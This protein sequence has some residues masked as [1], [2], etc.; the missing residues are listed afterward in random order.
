LDL[1][2]LDL[3][4]IPEMPKECLGEEDDE[5]K[6]DDDEE[7]DS[8]DDEEEEEEEDDGEDEELAIAGESTEAV[9][10][11]AV[12]VIDKDRLQAWSDELQKLIDNSTD[13]ILKDDEIADEIRRWIRSEIKDGLEWDK[14]LSDFTIEKLASQIVKKDK[15]E[16][17]KGK[18][19]GGSSLQSDAIL[20]Q[21]AERIELEIA[22]QT[23]RFD[24]ASI[25]NG[26][27]VVREGPRATSR[28]LVQSLPY[29]NRIMAHVGLRFYGYG[30]DAA[31]TPTDPPGA[32]GQCW[33]FMSEE[34]S[35]KRQK[36]KVAQDFSRGSVA[37]LTVRLARPTFV[38]SIV[39]EHPPKEITDRM[40][41]AIRAFRVVG[42]EDKI[43]SKGSY[44]LGRFAYKPDDGPRAEFDVA[45]KLSR[46]DVPKLR[47]IV[48]AIESTWGKSDDYGCLYRFRVHGDDNE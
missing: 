9:V 32:L 35:K 11:V 2:S 17:G 38:H 5:E 1:S 42:Y 31:L 24:F 21:I 22:D 19:K 36:S 4:E 8:D 27:V 33:A 14:V 46:R 12:P 16:G 10:E 30:A 15:K 39:I 18:S 20:A 6:E 41:S 26:A 48:L 43:G 23:G 45:R 7:E 25:R 44:E 3:W 34:A 29:F 47:S 13:D 37:T 40:D 28:S